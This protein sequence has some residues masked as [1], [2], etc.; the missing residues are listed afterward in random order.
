MGLLDPYIGVIHIATHMSIV[1]RGLM[2]IAG[3]VI[4]AATG[5]RLFIILAL[6]YFLYSS[7]EDS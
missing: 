5:L 2:Y 1:T 7:V 6:R 3:G 4:F